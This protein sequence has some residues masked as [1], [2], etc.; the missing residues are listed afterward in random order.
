M[1]VLV[2]AH[3]HPDFGP[4]GGE[5]AAHTL[6][7]G[8]KAHP[9]VSQA[10]FLARTGEPR[11][12]SGAVGRLRPGEHLIRRDIAD[13][14]RL[15]AC[16]DAPPPGRGLADFLSDAAPDVVFL[17]HVVHLG[18]EIVDDIR[19]TLPDARIVLTLH[20][21]LAICR[22]EGLMVTRPPGPDPAPLSGTLCRESGI[23][24]CGRCFPEG[25]PLIHTERRERFRRA[26]AQIDAFVA[27][28]AFLAE[29]YVRWGI[30][31]ERI[32]VIANGTHAPGR[33][34]A[35][36]SFGATLRLGFFGQAR[37][38]KGLHVALAA[39]HHLEPSVRA[40]ISL[41]LNVSRLEAQDAW[42]RT[43]VER[44]A[45]PLVQDG[46][47]RWRGAFARN[48]LSDR[49]ASV[50][51]VLVPSTWWENAPL[52]IGEAFAHGRPVLGSRLGGIAEAVRDGI[53]GCLFTPGDARE[54][55]GLLARLSE[56]AVTG[57]A[58]A[59]GVRAPATVAQSSDAHLALARSIG[60][61]LHV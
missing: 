45:A 60:A 43:L 52:V 29:R 21:Y 49:M 18:L 5:L 54:L 30:E 53:D 55:S 28:S 12:P 56:E 48:D 17:H 61:G 8:L 31:P 25:A 58:I 47:L 13:W 50:D 39:L 10:R 33:P 34:V 59:A 15:E 16:P 46:S 4:G 51:A 2:V 40:R 38:S 6:F 57:R 41:D 14:P 37:P 11:L 7:E 36:P 1:R 9:D 19:S 3:G 42:Y 24:A 44:L 22:N 27:P 32:H 26:F 23:D 20:D 35:P